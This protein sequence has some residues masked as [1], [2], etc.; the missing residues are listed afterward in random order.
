MAAAAAPPPPPTGGRTGFFDPQK[1]PPPPP[2]VRQHAWSI[3]QR[4][5]LIPYTEAICLGAAGEGAA[6]RTVCSRLLDKLSTW[7]FIYGVGTVAPL[8]N[9]VCWHSCDGQHTGGEN[10][11]SWTNCQQTQCARSP[12]KDFLLAECQ[13]IQHHA[14]ETKFRQTCEIV[15]PSPPFPPSP[16]PS[17]PEPPHYPSPHPPP[18]SVKFVERLRDFETESDPDCELVEFT[19]CQEIIR[20]FAQRSGAGYA[21]RMRV[22]AFG[23]EGTQVESDCFVG[24]AFGSRSGGTYRFL[25]EGTSDLYYKHTLPRCRLSDHPRCACANA[26]SPPPIGFSPPP[27]RKYT[28]DWEIVQVPMFDLNGQPRDTS[29]GAIG[30]MVQRMVNGRTLDLA[31]R[32]GP[33]HRY[34]CPG[35]NDGKDQCAMTCATNHLSRLRAF[36]VNHIC[37]H[38]WY[39]HKLT[40]AVIIVCSLHRLR[41]K[42]SMI[43]HLQARPL[44]HRQLDHRLS[45][46]R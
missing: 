37:F 23:C 21:S 40:V 42:V 8:C 46:R 11:D 36:T 24:C 27:P 34:Q 35:E 25:P 39:I 18:P 32:S 9:A 3:Y 30:A 10:D 45:V 6:H 20:Q 14:I 31:L 13:P 16:P 28:E 26:P 38:S 5:H 44:H 12:C 19:Q 29:R 2:T 15:P 4:E 33:M 1:A 7:Q 43:L 17:P 41:E 22:T